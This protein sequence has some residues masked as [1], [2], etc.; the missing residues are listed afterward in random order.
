M[1]GQRDTYTSR[2]TRNVLSVKSNNH[3]MIWLVMK[4]HRN[5]IFT[6]EIIRYDVSHKNMY[7]CTYIWIYLDVNKYIFRSAIQKV[8]LEYVI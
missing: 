6:N 5:L 3:D 8:G 2:T 7:L 1:F 4:Q